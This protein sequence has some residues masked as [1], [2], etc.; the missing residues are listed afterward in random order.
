MEASKPDQSSEWYVCGAFVIGVAKPSQ[1]AIHKTSAVAVHRYTT[2]DTDWGFS[3]LCT[4]NNLLAESNDKSILEND[5]LDL[6]CAL[7]VYK[8]TTGVLWHNFVNWDSKQKT[9][10][11]G[12]RNQGAT[13]YLNSLL[14]SLYFTNYFRKATYEIPTLNDDPA[15]S[16]PLA[17]QRLF[18]NMQFAEQAVGTNELTRSFGW[19]NMDAFF[20][21]DVQE[22]NRVLQDNLESKMKGTPA[23]GAIRKLFTGKMKSYIKCINVDYESSRV[24]DFYDIQLNVKGCKNLTESF[25]D[26]CATETLDGENKYFAEGFG[27]QDARKGVIFKNFP[28]VLHLQMKRFEYDMERDMLVKINDRHEFGLVIDLD[29]Y[30]DTDADKSVKQRYHL[31][32]VLVHSG[33]LNSGH[34]FS[35]IRP[36]IN[37]KWFKFDDDRVIPAS[38]YEVLDENFGG[39]HGALP[40][41]TP[42]PNLAKAIKRLTNAYMLVYIR[43]SDLEEILDPIA[44][45]DIPTHLRL[46]FDEEKLIQEKRR[47][48]VEEGHLYM[49]IKVL[50]QEMASK[51]N[52]FD[53]CVFDESGWEGIVTAEAIKVR[54]DTTMKNLKEMLAEKYQKPLAQIRLWSMVGRQNKTIRTDSPITS[55]Y[56]EASI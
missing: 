50:T 17:L 49:T 41:G 2:T 43:E 35:F 46:R 33:D 26:Y 21:H 44:V 4:W 47:K 54:K 51:H 1:E 29:D 7:K 18:Y 55:E 39:D 14:Q 31:H 16:V 36:E 6:V 53:L 19:D 12:L 9:G 37:G 32:G 42:K 10:Y 13:C 34:Y 45:T 24:E 27:L 22:L 30:L 25:I 38:E 5:S 23:E 40:P 15:K 11:V 56:D 3:S 48:D 8:D 52:G 28:P 20:Q